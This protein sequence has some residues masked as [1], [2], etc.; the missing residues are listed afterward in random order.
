MLSI[1]GHH[2]FHIEKDVLGHDQQ[3]QPD[4]PQGYLA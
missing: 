2:P 1:A 4:P 3:G